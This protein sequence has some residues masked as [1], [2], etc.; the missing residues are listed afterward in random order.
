MAQPRKHTASNFVLFD[1]VTYLPLRHCPT[2]ASR[3]F[4][5]T[6]FASNTL[7]THSPPL[8]RDRP[9]PIHNQVPLTVTPREPP[10]PLVP[11]RTRRARPRASRA[12]VWI[13]SL[14]WEGLFTVNGNFQSLVLYVSSIPFYFRPPAL[15]SGIPSYAWPFH[16]FGHRTSYMLVVYAPILAHL[17]TI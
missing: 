8:P 1:H 6:R 15:Y 3:H 13:T 11:C 9:F 16:H 12:S 10:K 7:P 2:P 17:T 4:R 5:P 14:C